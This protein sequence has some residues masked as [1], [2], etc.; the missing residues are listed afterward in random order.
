MTIAPERPRVAPAGGQ[1]PLGIDD[2]ELTIS[3]DPYDRRTNAENFDY[4]GWLAGFDPRLLTTSE[5]RKALTRLD[6]LLFAIVYL[7]KHLKDVLGRITFAD[8][9]FLWVRLARRW[10]GPSR[11]L[12]EDR[13]AL[14]APRSCG[15]STWWFLILPLWA[16]AHGH[17]RFAAAF[18]DS[19][20]QAELHLATFKREL[21]DNALLR[22]DFPDFCEP[23]RRHNGR[24]VN[25][26]QQMLYTRSGFAFA[27]RGIDSTSLGMKV[28]ETRP[29]LLIFDDIEPPEAT[30]SEY[31]KGNRL[32]TVQNAILPLNELA[33]VV[34][35]GT[36]TMPGS[37]VHELVRHGKGELD[38]EEDATKWIDEQKFKTHHTRPILRR[39]DGTRRSVWP[40]KWPLEYLESIEHTR[41]YKLN[42]DNDPR[43]RE[44][45]FWNAEDLH[46]GVPTIVTR[47]FLFVDPPV[48]Q[49]KTSDAAGLAVVGYSPRGAGLSVAEV[50]RRLG[51][52]PPPPRADAE[53]RKEYYRQFEHYEINLH[54]SEVDEQDPDS[55]AAPKRLSR[56]IIYD[57]WGRQ[58]TG[59]KLKAHILDTLALWPRVEAVVVENNQGG[60]LWLE[61]LDGLPVKLITYPATE[62]KEVRFAR[63]L[64]RWQ[65]RRVLIAKY[66][67]AL[68]DQLTGF[69]NFGADDI[70]DAAV[71]GVL[72]LL[73]HPKKKSKKDTTLTPK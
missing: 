1:H 23:M 40:D 45:R 48:T 13:R 66:N 3:V 70:A 69:P 54:G 15:K 60:D 62:S 65:G 28:D 4:R 67:S 10:I 17:A 39:S 56:A 29:D 31:Q 42:Y 33:R 37:I 25:D 57:A 9:H 32:S 63:A 73:P 55:L 20:T 8:A 36:V 2:D 71:A 50:L 41:S 52:P 24:T 59:R 5:G 47:Q 22:A 6:P 35:V 7:R 18:A 21:S 11:G 38:P 26:S 58:L 34:L 64:E 68:E 53:Q 43:G 14:V 16:G 12:R 27:A 30:Y 72:R 46:Y 19:A 49:K 51:V 44:G 61:V